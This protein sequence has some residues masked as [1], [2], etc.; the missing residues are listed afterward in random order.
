MFA[1]LLCLGLGGIVGTYVFRVTEFS[2]AWGAISAA[3]TFVVLQLLIG[4]FVR[5]KIKK[6]TA[7][8]QNIVTD[9]QKKLN[10][11]MQFFQ[12]KPSGG[13]K[14]MQKILEK[15]Q[16]VFLN[17]AL[18]ETKR[19]EPYYSW[20]LLLK[21]QVYTMRMQFYYQL[22]DFENV[23]KLLNKVMLVDHM[24]VAMKIARQYMNN[25]K[26]YEKTFKKKINKFKG[27]N[28]ALLYALYSWILVKENRI[29]KA[30]EVLRKARKKAKNEILERNLQNLIHGKIKKFSNSGF[31]DQWYSLHLEEPKQQKPKQKV[32]RKR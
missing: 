5:K 30:I 29:E 21:K 8:V 32:V 23:D 20:N 26:N 7:D 22:K 2:I 14:N 28:A 24:T 10:K 13:V 1:L 31:G 3:V 17:Q 27:D 9:G 12:Q 16:Q 19:L 4:L 6:I 25:D 18:E 11:K 15:D